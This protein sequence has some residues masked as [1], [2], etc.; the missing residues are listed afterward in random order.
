MK[1]STV[2]FIVSSLA[3]STSF[4]HANPAFGTYTIAD[5]IDVREGVII[6]SEGTHGAQGWA[7][8]DN[9]FA[10]DVT[11]SYT[12]TPKLLPDTADYSN[13]SQYYSFMLLRKD[14]GDFRL[15]TN[16]GNPPGS[17]FFFA[18]LLTET[19]DLLVNGEPI[20]YED[21][22]PYDIQLDIQYVAG[23]DDSAVLS[24]DGNT[25]I[26]PTGDYSFKWI[27][28]MAVHDH[29]GPGADFT[30]MS[31]AVIPEPRTAALLFGVFGLAFAFHLR[32]RRS[33]S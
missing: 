19:K 15:G 31:V 28:I 26:L 17:D 24:I 14:P 29:P 32:H 20:R 9:T 21:G 6:L 8:I 10:G 27:D 22:R 16:H 30:N 33:G 13:F 4:L 11:I 1:K 18:R 23:A 3:A 25:F 2:C 7:P 12:M 5:Q